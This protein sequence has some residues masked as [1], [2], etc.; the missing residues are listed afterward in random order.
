MDDVVAFIAEEGSGGGA[1]AVRINVGWAAS[2]DDI[3][4]CVFLARWCDASP[5]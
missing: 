2:C 3:I 4:T 1:E 5:G